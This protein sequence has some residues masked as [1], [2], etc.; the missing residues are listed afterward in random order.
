MPGNNNPNPQP[1]LPG[2]LGPFDWNPITFSGI[3]VSGQMQVTLYAD[4]GYIFSGQFYDPDMLDYDDSLAFVI[5]GNNGVAFTFTHTGNMHGWGDRWFEGGSNTDSWNVTGNNPAIQANWAALC[6]EYNWQSNASIN[7]DIGSVLSD[8]EDIIKA[9]QTVVQ[10][11]QV[12]VALA[13]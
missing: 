9:I 2:Q 8:V 6:A 4:G 5:A 1:T 12:V 7:V 10:I 13:A 3:G 11:V